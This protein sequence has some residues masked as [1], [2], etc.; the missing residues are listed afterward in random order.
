MESDLPSCT[1][2]NSGNSHARVSY[3]PDAPHLPLLADTENTS[4]NKNKHVVLCCVT[5]FLLFLHE[6]NI[7]FGLF[8]VSGQSRFN[9]GFLSM[10]FR[11]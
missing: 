1:E 10:Q 2:P 3:Q 6:Q 11:Q 8:F 9:P 7:P 4:L 5:W